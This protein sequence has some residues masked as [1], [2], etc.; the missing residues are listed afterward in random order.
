[1]KK[2]IALIGGSGF[3][4]TNLAN[5]FAE[6]N[7]NVL[8]IGRSSID[9]ERFK[10]DNI[11]TVLIDVNH[12]SKLIEALEEY[13]NVIWL[14]NNL[15]PGLKMDSLVDDFNLN[16]SPLVKFLELSRDAMQM[17]RFIFI[18]SGGTIY[19]D[20]VNNTFFTETCPAK[21]ISAYGMSKIVSENYVEYITDKANFDSYILRPS[22]VY[23]NFQNLVK[24]Q[25]IIGFAFNAVINNSTIELFGD[26]MV[27]RDFVH[28]LD[29]ATAIECCVN[30]IY[31]GSKVEKYNVA[32]QNGYTIKEIIDLIK[33]ITHTP[34]KTISKPLR[35]FDCIYNVLDISK[36]ETNLHWKPKIDIKEGLDSVWKWMNIKS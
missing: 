34:I 2:S 36:I 5:F 20:S 16:V 28:V 23:G 24:P 17:K 31:E 30:N 14:V 1:M 27:T 3:I 4:G 19:G 32:S 7:Y 22:N 33:E 9:K 25:G 29:L 21:P 26:G 13:E 15:L 6:K 11:K 8:V 18:S 35:D 10:S 12:T